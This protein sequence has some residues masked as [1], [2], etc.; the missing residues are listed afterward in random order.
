MRFVFAFQLK[1]NVAN[2]SA[3]SPLRHHVIVGIPDVVKESDATCVCIVYIYIGNRQQVI[4]TT[5]SIHL[6]SP[7]MLHC[8]RRSRRL[9]SRKFYSALISGTPCSKVHFIRKQ[10]PFP[11]RWG[12][13]SHLKWSSV[14]DQH[15]Q[16]HKVERSTH[17]VSVSKS[18]FLGLRE[19]HEEL[20]IRDKIATE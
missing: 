16:V 8:S 14:Q 19:H 17:H 12:E 4:T 10:L 15:A 11:T 7:E 2:R 9:I 1:L 20:N 5:Q 13:L 6:L 3:K 18:Q